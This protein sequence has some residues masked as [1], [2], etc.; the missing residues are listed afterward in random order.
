MPVQH[1]EVLVEE[2]SMGE[3]LRE[4]LPRLLGPVSFQIH[5]FLCK[6][7]LIKRL[8]ERLLGYARWMP[9]TWAL[10]VVV[11]RDRDDCFELKKN[12]ERAASEAGFIKGF[13]AIGTGR[14]V[15]NRIAVEELEAWY[16]GDWNAVR[17]AYPRVPPTLPNKR[18]YRDPDAIAGGT[19]EAFERELQRAGYYRGGIPKLQ[20]A[21]AIA[22]HLTPECNASHSF[23]V[24]LRAV[25]ALGKR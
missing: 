16:F 25:R 22:P 12:L 6:P 5:V 17:T 13:E 20:V 14:A 7:D 8:P 24:F 19:W 1:V 21:R 11:D 9:A 15:V 18:K 10:L 4:L 23:Q 2:P 3:V